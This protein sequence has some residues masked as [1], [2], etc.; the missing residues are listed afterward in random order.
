MTGNMLLRLSRLEGR[1]GG[2]AMFLVAASEDEA[3]EL[4]AEAIANGNARPFVLIGDAPVGNPRCLCSV[5]ELMARV[6]RHGRHIHE[7]RI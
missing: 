2:R 5:A 6:A 7:A 3:E 1:S 4:R